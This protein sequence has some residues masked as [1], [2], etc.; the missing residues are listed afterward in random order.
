[1]QNE[2]WGDTAQEEDDEPL[3]DGP[4]KSQRKRDSQA[5][6]DLGA[7][8]TQL[9]ADVLKRAGLP[10]DIMA[11][12]DDFRRMKSFGAQRRQ[13]QF[14]GKIM[15]AYDGEAI[16]EAVNRANGTSTMAQS[17]KRRCERLI[18]QF[19]E[20]DETF[21]GFVNTHPD[22]DIKRIRQLT[23]LARKEKEAQQTKK[24]ASR[25]L[26]QVLYALELPPVTEFFKQEEDA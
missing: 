11:A 8:L 19:I 21:T 14:L 24:P 4:S 17:A 16:R 22:C 26:Y 2:K 3:Y 20:S 10:E 25:E 15:R 5:M 23:R 7:E 12:I 6:Q 18:A 1:M 13:L 9:P